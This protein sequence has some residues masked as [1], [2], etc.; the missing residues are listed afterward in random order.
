MYIKVS[1]KDKKSKFLELLTL[2]L[3]HLQNT[4]LV[5]FLNA[6]FRNDKHL[7]SRLHYIVNRKRLP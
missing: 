7:F 3:K 2:D 5:T 4:V 1:E 6:V